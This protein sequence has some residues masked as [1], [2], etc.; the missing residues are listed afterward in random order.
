MRP[1]KLPMWA[2]G[3]PLDAN[4][5]AALAASPVIRELFSTVSGSFATLRPA[6]VVGAVGVAGR[7]AP[8]VGVTGGGRRL[9]VADGVVD[10]V[11]GEDGPGRG[12]GR[13]DGVREW[14]RTARTTATTAVIS[15]TP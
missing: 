8:G 14:S 4:S 2:I 1:V 9:G 7:V 12:D 5:A 10:G 15:S 3:Q 6:T 11:V 13:A